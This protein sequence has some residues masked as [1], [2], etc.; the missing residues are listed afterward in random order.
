MLSVENNSNLKRNKANQFIDDE[1]DSSELDC[2]SDEGKSEKSHDSVNESEDEEGKIYT[3]TQKSLFV[4]ITYF[5]T[6]PILLV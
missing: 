2:S 4:Y 6:Y 1:A 3:H 5:F